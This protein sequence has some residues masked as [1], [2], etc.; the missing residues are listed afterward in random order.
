M[1]AN[2]NSNGVVHGDKSRRFRKK[3]VL[4]S[5]L[6]ELRLKA[7]ERILPQPRE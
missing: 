6:C 5:G 4:L 3:A 2:R 7:Y 1:G